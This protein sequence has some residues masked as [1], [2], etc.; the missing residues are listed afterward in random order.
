ML[1]T[2][3]G[4]VVGGAVGATVGAGVGGAAEVGAGVGAVVSSGAAVVVLSPATLVVAAPAVVVV[5]VTSVVVVSIV[6]TSPAEGPE[7]ALLL[8]AV[9]ASNSET[10]RTATRRVILQFK[11]ARCVADRASVDVGGL[12]Q[13]ED[14]LSAP[15]V[16]LASVSL[17]AVSLAAV[18]LASR[19]GVPWLR[20][21]S[22][23]RTL[24]V[25]R[26]PMNDM[27]PMSTA[28]VRYMRHPPLLLLPQSGRS[29]VPT[30]ELTFA[31]SGVNT[32]PAGSLDGVPL[33]ELSS[34]RRS[35]VHR[36]AVARALVPADLV[37]VGLVV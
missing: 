1:T 10:V 8:H 11:H 33:A 15:A 6:V 14:E 35:R 7:L 5:S 20:M 18:S 12:G 31:S 37:V 16:S 34:K 3:Q 23:W 21:A 4:A 13:A 22:R 19:S 17:A 2:R 29:N 36:A 30:Q 27:P 26:Q 25:M 9:A 24:F 32:L 28:K